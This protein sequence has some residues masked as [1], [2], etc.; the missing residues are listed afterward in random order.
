M[1]CPSEF[2]TAPMKIIIVPDIFGHTPALTRLTQRLACRLSET[3]VNASID[4]I[5]PYGEKRFFKQENQAYDYFT[6]NLDIPGYS[7][8]I[9]KRLITVKGPVTLLGFSAGASAIWHFSGKVKKPGK[10][11]GIGFYGSQIRYHTGISP[12]FDIEL[13]FPDTESHFNVDDLIENLGSTPG[14]TI[15]KADGLHGFMNEYSK[16]FSPD[17]CD[18]FLNIIIPRRLNLRSK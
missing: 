4:I 17:L 16:N 18:E 9:K 10:I 7:D 3:V 13:I 15:S 2:G 14:L 5:D 1:D 6:T 12:G 11:R 8:I